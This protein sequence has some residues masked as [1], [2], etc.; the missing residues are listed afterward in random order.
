MFRIARLRAEM[1]G[2]FSALPAKANGKYA[3]EF[4]ANSDEMKIGLED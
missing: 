2:R 4:R 3:P 1:P